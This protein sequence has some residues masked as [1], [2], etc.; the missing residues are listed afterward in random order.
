MSGNGRVEKGIVRAPIPLPMEE[1]ML[2]SSRTTSSMVMAPL[3][4][5]MEESMSGNGVMENLGQEPN[6]TKVET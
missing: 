1:S 6:T 4:G 2:G 3:R 5:P